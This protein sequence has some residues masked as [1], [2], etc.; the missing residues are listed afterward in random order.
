MNLRVWRDSAHG[1]TQNQQPEND[2]ES[3]SERGVDQI[4]AT[5]T[6]SSPFK[7]Q[8]EASSSRPGS[9]RIRTRLESV[10]PSVPSSATDI[11]DI[12]LDALIREEEGLMQELSGGNVATSKQY[13][14]A[15]TVT[16]DDEEALWATGGAPELD[17]GP[18]AT[19]FG[20]MGDDD[21]RDPVDKIRKLST[22]REESLAPSKPPSHSTTLEDGAEM[23]TLGGDWDDMYE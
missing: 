13:Q 23:L 8:S 1:I 21:M 17:R 15:G 10:A 18:F 20:A 6:P 12:D 19:S 16:T 7:A 22:T 4:N 5:E 9:P 11:D 14:A 2:E 3:G